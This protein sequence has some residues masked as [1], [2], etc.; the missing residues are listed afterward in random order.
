MEISLSLSSSTTVVRRS[1][2]GGFEGDLAIGLEWWRSIWQRVVV[3]VKFVTEVMEECQSDRAFNHFVVDGVVA[4]VRV[5]VGGCGVEKLAIGYGC[6]GG[7]VSP[8]GFV[9]AERWY[10]VFVLVS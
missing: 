3:E 5:G 10:C 2:V 8:T 4:V 7:I 1:T 9:L 6:C